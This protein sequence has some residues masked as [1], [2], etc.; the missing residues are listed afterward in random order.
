MSGN[1]SRSITKHKSLKINIEVLDYNS[2]VFFGLLTF[3]S[4]LDLRKFTIELFVY[5]TLEECS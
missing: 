3:S 5:Y 4:E 1:F 2:G